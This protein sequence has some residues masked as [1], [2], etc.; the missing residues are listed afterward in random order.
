MPLLFGSSRRDQV[1]LLSTLQ[2]LNPASVAGLAAA[3]SWSE[4]KTERIVRE[5]ATARES[6]V[7]YDAGRR[8]VSIRRASPAASVAISGGVAAPSSPPSPASGSAL[9]SPEPPAVAAKMRCPTCQVA[10]LPTT[11]GEAA[12]CPK[13]GRLSTRSLAAAPRR[14]GPEAAPVAIGDAPVPLETGR[15]VVHSGDRRSQE[16]L[17]AWVTARPIPCP[18]CRTT[19]R[20]RG[21]GEYGC[22]SC[23]HLVTFETS[24]SRRDDA[25][26]PVPPGP[27]SRSA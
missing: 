22:P 23:G 2:S 13:C 20:H 14:P 21:V 8:L 24:F 5:V 17:A 9:R 11:T 25:R 3:L 12:V 18:R 26:A 4:R 15:T 7:V 19:L 16:L 6:L 1:H 10:L 27:A